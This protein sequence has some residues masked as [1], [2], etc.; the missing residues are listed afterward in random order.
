MSKKPKIIVEDNTIHLARRGAKVL[1]SA[2]KVSIEERKSFTL[3]ISGGSTPRKMHQMMTTEPYI[4][5]MSWDKT[6]IFWVDERCVPAK[7]P[8]S[9]YGVARTDFLDKI[10]V[11]KSQIHPMPG[12][13]PPES[14]AASYQ[15]EL[16]D[17]F[18][19]K[20]NQIPVFD[21][22]FLGIGT[23]GHTASLFPG[24][25][26]LDEKDQPVVPVKGGNP[27][28]SRITMTFPVL[29]N[30]RQIVFLVS[31]DKKARIIQQILKNEKSQLPAQM[32]KPKT[33]GLIWL[34]DKDAASLI[35][36]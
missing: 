10:P 25:R 3:A 8:F 29:N 27:N 2:A 24:Q 7:D 14:G 26:A 28:V 20:G 15:K 16:T 35:S 21:L 13:I 31:G 1:C 11:E 12:E 9:N 6:H 19:L 32:V 17:F 22:I 23:D 18:H 5:Q 36:L 34:L 4:S 30:A 33:G